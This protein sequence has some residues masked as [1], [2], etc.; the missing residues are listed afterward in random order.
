MFF[1]SGADTIG[2]SLRSVP[3]FWEAEQKRS[4]NSGYASGWKDSRQQ[5][6]NRENNFPSYWGPKKAN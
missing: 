1:G 4:N 6:A 5:S 3:V 2:D